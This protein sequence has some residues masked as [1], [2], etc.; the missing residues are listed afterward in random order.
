MTLAREG[1]VPVSA[2]CPAGAEEVSLEIAA[3]GP[4]LELAVEAPGT[5]L[6][7]G[8]PKVGA[9]LAAVAVMRAGAPEDRIA[10]LEARL[11]VPVA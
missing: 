10:Y 7:D 1:V 5:P 2:E 9:G 4:V 3:G 11:L 8:G 6:P